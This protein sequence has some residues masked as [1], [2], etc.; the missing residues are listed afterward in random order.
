MFLKFKFVSLKALLLVMVIFQY[1]Y[2]Q[3]SK[4]LADYVNPYIGSISPK[5]QG[6]SPLVYVPHGAV[7][8]APQF[9]PNIG[10]EYLADKIY[11]FPIGAASLMATVGDVKN[12]RSENA[13]SFDHG[14]ETSKP[15]YYEALLEDSNI[16]AEYTVTDHSMYYR[17]TFPQ[18]ANSNILMSIF[19]NGS[20]EVIGDNSVEG[21]SGTIRYYEDTG[22]MEND[23]V[24]FY[25]E[26]NKSLK[27][28]GTWKDKNISKGTKIQSGDS[29]GVFVNFPTIKNEQVEI[30]IGI[31]YNSI[32]EARENMAKE[33]P[34]WD[35]EQ[36]KNKAK[37]L[38][39]QALG[40]IKVEGGT[41][42]QRIAFYTALYRTMGRK[43]NVW[44][45]YRCA[46]PL[47][48]IIEPE[49]TMEAIREFVSVYEKTGWLPS[50]DA[51]IG[52]HSTAVITDAYMKGL[53]N[54]DIEKAYEGMKK[55]ATEATMIPWRDAGHITELEKCYF[56]KGYYPALPVREDMKLKDIAEWPT[57]VDSII[58]S[59]MPYQITWLPEV[60]EKEWVKEVDPWHRRQ[61]VSVTL[62]HSY[63]DWCLAQMAK[64]LGKDEDY[65]IFIK[66]ALNYQNLYDST[67]G[68]MAPKT[69]DGQW[70][71]PFD[72][73]LSGGFAGE[74]YFAECNSWVYTW[75]VQ[76][77]VQGLIN[78]M[79]G[80]EKFVAKLNVLFVEQYGMD[81]PAFLGQ[82]PDMSGLIG[83]YCQGNEP[84][85]HI[86]YLY[87]FAG[88]PWLTQRRA[89]EIMNLWYNAGPFGLPGDDD[90]GA[91]SA[92]YVFSAM[93]FYPVCPGSGQYAIGS[94]LFKKITLS[95]ENGNKFVIESKNNSKKNV[96]IK[97]AKLN[98]KVY[99]KNYITH[100][101]ILKGGVLN[102][103]MSNVPNKNRGTEKEDFPY[104]FSS[105]IK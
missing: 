47:Q 14:L 70:V 1:G 44:D 105:E 36:T 81:K 61:S 71:R 73:K 31:S 82:F 77:D 19:H 34:N 6:T 64:V 38:W 97:E 26:F 59:Q 12:N 76:H 96:Y 33:I 17:F 27:S 43:G 75:S 49:K 99:N 46:Y 85:F 45:A 55:N 65:K 9:T 2:S 3:Q 101:E 10:D 42:D 83:M 48:T 86:S 87:D 32:N 94:P 98:N 30:R 62:E 91:M 93:G 35:F 24:Y 28:F 13:S 41:E 51:M 21:S 39:N 8:A 100:R 80:R 58:G 5:T 78:L 29:I 15:Y 104:S 69:A 23:K 79:G 40:L 7:E 95:L 63:D 66:R 54:F 50:S 67:I 92:W 52:N 90:D 4:E 102:F 72:P 37:N 25:A 89:R 20:I 22:I 11:G 57:D 60:G 74:D 53:R 56:E 103:E 84:A 16:N 18:S 88:A 68:F